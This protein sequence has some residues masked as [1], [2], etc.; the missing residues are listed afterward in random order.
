MFEQLN[1]T[2]LLETDGGVGWIPVVVVAVLVTGC[3]ASCSN[4]CDK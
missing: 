1:N 2:E 3:L 4:S